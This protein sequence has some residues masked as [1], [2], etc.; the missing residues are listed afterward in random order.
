MQCGGDII[1]EGTVQ[2]FPLKFCKTRWVENEIVAT[3]AI[4][5]WGDNDIVGKT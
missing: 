4:Q 2:S 3:R 1:K 5:I